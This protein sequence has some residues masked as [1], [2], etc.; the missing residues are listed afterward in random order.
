MGWRRREDDGGQGQAGEA[1]CSKPMVEAPEG[2]D[3]AVAVG[4]GV[5]GGQY[6]EGSGGHRRRLRQEDM[7]PKRRAQSDMGG[8]S[9]KQL[10]YE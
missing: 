10:G 4:L 7:A 3:G 8:D 5:S 2:T 1:T 6:S 9:S